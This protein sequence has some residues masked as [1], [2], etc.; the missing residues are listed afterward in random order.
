MARRR[1]Q[2]SQVR[3]CAG[4]EGEAAA[5]DDAADLPLGAA[6]AEH[7]HQAAD[8]D[9]DER[10]RAGERAG[11]RASRFAAARSQGEDWAAL[12]PGTS[13]AHAIPTSTNQPPRTRERPT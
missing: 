10:E 13:S 7:E 4:E 2:N 12:V 11:E 6:L 5:E 8:H 9:R 1:H 3:N